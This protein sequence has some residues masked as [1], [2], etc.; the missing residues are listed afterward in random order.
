MYI[1]LDSELKRIRQ[2]AREEITSLLSSTDCFL[3]E[4][5][6]ENSQFVFDFYSKLGI[7]AE[8]IGHIKINS[9]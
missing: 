5:S 1:A 9:E 2:E 8:D 6:E 7:S 3:S 4:L